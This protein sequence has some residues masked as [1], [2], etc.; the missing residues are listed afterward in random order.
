MLHSTGT[1][2]KA[3]SVAAALLLVGC[4]GSKAV[5]E[6]FI[7][8]DETLNLY[9]KMTKRE[10]RTMLGKPS[11]VRAGIVLNNGTVYEVWAYTVRIKTEKHGEVR[12]PDKEF[13]GDNWVGGTDYE[14]VFK[15]DQLFKWGS[16]GDDWRDF[17]FEDGDV[18][19]PHPFPPDSL[20]TP[21]V[22]SKKDGGGFKLPFGKK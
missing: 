3:V 5:V 12:K 18:I 22:D 2:G 8:V 19:G 21:S 16:A 20:H 4:A 14:L 17:R 11:E 6:Q 10:A 7:D 1:I 9:P 13:R 15:N